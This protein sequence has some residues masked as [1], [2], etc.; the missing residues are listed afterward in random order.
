MIHIGSIFDFFISI[1]NLHASASGNDPT[2]RVWDGTLSE[3]PSKPSCKFLCTGCSHHHRS[4]ANT[5]TDSAWEMICRKQSQLVV[6]I[7]EGVGQCPSM[8]PDY[9][10]V[11]SQYISF[12]IPWATTRG[13][14]EVLSF[15]D[16]LL[17]CLPNP[18]CCPGKN[19]RKNILKLGPSMGKLAQSQQNGIWILDNIGRW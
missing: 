6:T 14:I 1:H 18:W 13:S 3:S 10:R 17:C 2:K 15:M 19:G 8:S 16:S 4:Q 9:M 12:S 11:L 7:W 5:Q